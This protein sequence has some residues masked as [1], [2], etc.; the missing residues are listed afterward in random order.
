M[1]QTIRYLQFGLGPI[2][3]EILKQA[4]EAHHFNVLGAVDI[5]PAKVGKDI[6]EFINAQSKG[7]KVVANL[8]ELELSDE[9][10]K[11]AIHATGSNLEK[12]WPQIKH[13]LDHGFSVVSTCEEL[14][15]PWYRYAELSKEIDDYAKNKG[16]FVIGTG[17]NPGFIMD[18]MTLFLTSVTNKVT[19]INVSRKVDVSK[20]RI[21][22]QKK[23]GVGMTV[24]QFNELAAE[25][26]IGHVGLEESARLIAY[27]LGISLNEV[28]NSIQP[29]I[30]NK[31]YSLTS[32]NLKPGQVSGQHQIVEATTTDGRKITLEL[33]MAV[34]VE[35]E[36]RIR[37]DGS[38]RTELVIPNGIFGDTAT[39]A[40]SINV[41]K[42]VANNP[43]V[44]LLTMADIPLS[45]NFQIRAQN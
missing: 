8:D 9:N 22:L 43:T 41:A 5:D 7:I 35:Q 20:R 19:N 25:N 18:T 42:T 31:A 24:D 32:G 44:G 11:V 2:G 15:Y 38:E 21:P 34:D 27:G 26:K 14:S 10:P 30:A 23:V 29:V 6:G 1:G 45:R 33:V 37:I 40:M 16:L 28:K 17:V 36:D 39:A 12:V 4:T 13:L 3:L